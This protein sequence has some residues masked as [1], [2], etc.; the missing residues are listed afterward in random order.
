MEEYAGLVEVVDTTLA[1]R[2]RQEARA[3]RALLN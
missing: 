1:E 2:V 3:A